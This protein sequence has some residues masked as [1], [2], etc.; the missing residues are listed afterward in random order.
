MERPRCSQQITRQQQVS[1]IGA[2][3]CEGPEGPR[4]RCLC[5]GVQCPQPLG[6]FLLPSVWC[7]GSGHQ[8]H[9]GACEK[10]RVSGPAQDL[11]SQNLHFD[12]MIHVHNKVQEPFSEQGEYQRGDPLAPFSCMEALYL[13]STLNS[14]RAFKN[15]SAVDILPN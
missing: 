10:R 4:R 1:C 6:R 7:L 11:L 14:L 5:N 3:S 13:G 8:H 2:G 12:K 9:L 15:P